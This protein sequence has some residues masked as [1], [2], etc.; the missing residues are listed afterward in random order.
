[1]KEEEIIHT[2]EEK[3]YEQSIERKYRNYKWVM[4]L[5]IGGVAFMFLTITFYYLLEHW[6]TKGIKLKILPIFYWNTLILIASSYVIQLAKKYFRNDNYLSYKTSLLLVL[7]SGI[8]LLFGQMAGWLAMYKGGIMQNSHEAAY[9]FTIFG[10]YALYSFGAIIFLAFF[11][12]KSN[13]F[14]HDYATSVVYFTD[15]IVRHQLNLFSL[16]WYALGVI[17]IYLI[18]FFM[19]VWRY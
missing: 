1:M 14:L 7:G 9:F 4:Y 17:W 19:L 8:L 16:F 18:F 15:P 12:F 13:K 2:S 5:F 6:G 3:I 10:L 11:T